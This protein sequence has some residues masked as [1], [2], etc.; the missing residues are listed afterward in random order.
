MMHRSARPTF[1]RPAPPRGFT[2]LEVLIASMLIAVLMTS[3]WHI[4][5]LYTD[6]FERGETRTEE[7][8]LVRT[9]AQQFSDD[10]AGAI[11][12]PVFIDPN[13]PGPTGARRFGLYGSSSE[14]RIDVLQI[15]AFETAPAVTAK[16]MENAAAPRKLQ[17]PELRTVYYR[18]QGAVVAGAGEDERVGLTRRELDFETPE[19]LD[20]NAPAPAIGLASPPAASPPAASQAAPRGQPAAFDQLLEASLASSVTWAPEVIALKFRYF[21]GSAWQGS[22]DSLAKRGLPVAVEVTMA[23]SSWQGAEAIR[24][25]AAAA[26]GQ[27]IAGQPLSEVIGPGAKKKTPQPRVHRVVVRLPNS[28]HYKPPQ[29]IRRRAA[30]RIAAP[31]PLPKVILTPS[32]P[33]QP[34]QRLAPDQWI[35][36]E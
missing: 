6:M 33:R 32:R 14:L 1:R 17:A 15:P 24:S 36:N 34:A 35:R 7:S 8:Q 27:S 21:D 22:W 25:A 3:A 26:A 12:D 5:G 18:F 28:P 20:E 31:A 19:K 30:P 11:Q 16:E 2:L 29:E 10:L 23:V 13:S 9:L 4:L